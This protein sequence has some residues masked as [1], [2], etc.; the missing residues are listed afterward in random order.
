M[1]LWE[2]WACTVAW[3][4]TIQTDTVDCYEFI[5]IVGSHIISLSLFYHY[6]CYERLWPVLWNGKTLQTIIIFDRYE[7]VILLIHLSFH[8]SLYCYSIVAIVNGVF[9]L[10]ISLLLFYHHCCGRVG[11]DH[12][13]IILFYP[14]YSCGRVW[15]VCYSLSMIISL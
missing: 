10:V 11:H 3:Q 1:L 15:L 6:F 14:C 12:F 9:G 5:I 13:I 7:F 4:S 8:Y 2:G